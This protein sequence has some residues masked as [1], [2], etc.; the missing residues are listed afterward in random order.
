MRRAWIF[1]LG[2]LLASAA[3]VFAEQPKAVVVVGPIDPPGNRLT[4][5]YVAEA[6]QTALLLEAGG[7]TVE[8]LYHP[9][10]SWERLRKVSRDARLFVYY[11]HGNGYGWQGY[12]DS[13]STNGLTLS[14]PEDP[15]LTSTGPGVPGGNAEDLAQL[16]LAPGSLVVLVHACHAAG[17]SVSDPAPVDYSLAKKRVSG[18]AQAFFRA[19]ADSYLA[20]NYEGM[21]PNFFRRMLGGETRRQTFLGLMER[22]RL[23]ESPGALLAQKPNGKWR[24]SWVSALVEKETA[25]QVAL[26]AAAQKPRTEHRQAAAE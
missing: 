24:G 20:I 3:C 5:A 16:Q 14:D 22:D 21:A 18:Y 2:V 4:R 7:Y 9:R 23:H 11:G 26:A 12:T 6:E 15:D 13:R 1:A 17:E 25:T 10:A 19:G 8:R